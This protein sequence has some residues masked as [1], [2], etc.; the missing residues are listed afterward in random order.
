M[1]W[2]TVTDEMMFPAKLVPIRDVIT[3][4]EILQH[5]SRIYDPLG[6]LSP[7]TVRAKTLLQELWR[8]KYSWDTALPKHVYEKWSALVT[9]L[10]NVMNTKV[11]RYYFRDQCAADDRITTVEEMSLHIFVD[12]STLSY[13][14]TAYLC[15]SNQSTFVM[16]KTRVAPLKKLTLPRLELMAAVVGSRLANH[17]QSS[18]NIDSNN[19]YLWSDSQIVLHWLQTTKSLKRF[20][21]NRVEEIQQLTCSRNWKYCPTQD[22]PADLMTRGISAIQFTNS[23]IWM[24]G[25]SWITKPLNWPTWHTNDATGMTTVSSDSLEYEQGRQPPQYSPESRTELR[26]VIDVTKFSKYTKLQRVTAYVLRFINKCREKTYPHHD[27]LTTSELQKAEKVLLHS[28]QHNTYQEEITNLRTVRSR[29]NQTR[30]PIVKQLRLFLDEDGFLRCGG[31]I[32]NADLDE[33][34]KFPYLIPAKD[35]LTRLLVA[36][37]HE[38]LLHAGQNSVITYLRQKYWIPSIRQSVRTVLRRC[39]V[40]RRTEGKAYSAPDPPPLPQYRVEDAPPFTV[41]GVDFSGALYVRDNSNNETKAYNCLFTCASTRAVHL[42]LVPNLSEEAFLQAFRRFTSR[43]SVSTLMIS[44]NAS[45][46]VAASNHIQRLFE[47]KTVQDALSMKGTQWKFIPK[48]APWYGGWWERLIGLTKSTLKKILGR[49]YISFDALQTVVTEIEAVMNDRP[50]TYVTSSSSDPEPLTPAHLLYGR[51]LTTLPYQKSTDDSA[52]N[53]NLNSGVDLSRQAR[54]QQKV[55]HHFRDRWR[56]EYLTALREHHQTTGINEQ[57][58][59]VGDVV[60]IHDESP[61]SQW[62]LAVVQ[63]LIYGNDGYTRAAKIRT[64]NGITNRPIVKLYPLEMK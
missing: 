3:K 23:K 60:Q 42:E 7:V 18:C 2:N 16:A 64:S 47:S 29:P 40:C 13:G 24:N 35:P 55:V 62:K 32:H 61:R 56:H 44:D 5:S 4:R 41:T 8:Q 43:R 50:L 9:D 17:L 14:A 26:N 21:K 25:P 39:L 53:T 30:L 38:R 20:V 45:T 33:E 34:A 31:R 28:C 49:S 51:R 15:T 58:I 22:N 57:K 48:R 46:Y 10:N 11:S 52:M 59:N 27:Q 63:E 19:T 12:A 37:A 6:L 1:L 36:D 54:L